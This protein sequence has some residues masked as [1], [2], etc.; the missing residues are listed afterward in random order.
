MGEGGRSS[1]RHRLTHS[2]HNAPVM[3]TVT[4][5]MMV[6]DVD[7]YLTMYGPQLTV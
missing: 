2:P 7:A 1:V 5:T 4:V 3:V 6:A